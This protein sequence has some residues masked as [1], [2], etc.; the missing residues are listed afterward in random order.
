MAVATAQRYA[1]TGA[2]TAPP[3]RAP[4]GRMESPHRLWIMLLAAV[5]AVLL[6]GCVA[7][8]GLSGRQSTAEHT[9]QAT[10]ALYS[11]VQ[12][13]SYNLADANA[14]AA[15]AL[16]IGPVTPKPFTDRFGSDITQVEDLLSAASQ[17]VTGDATASHELRL[18][19]EQVPEYSQW[20]GEALANNRFGYP[21]AGAYLRQAS[22][23]LTGSMVPEVDTVITEEQN[24]TEN[25]ISSA[26][27]TDW[28]TVGVCVLAL[29]VLVL[30]GSVLARSTKRR[31]NLGVVAAKLAVLVLLGWTFTAAVGSSGAASTARGDFDLIV[32]TQV[33]ASQ[34]AT[35]E[36]YIALQQ[37]DRGENGTGDQQQATAALTALGPLTYPEFQAATGASK[38]SKATATAIKA[39]VTCG[40]GAINQAA[41]GNYAQAIITTVGTGSDVGQGGCEPA[42]QQVRDDLSALTKQSQGHY[43]TDMASVSSAYAGGGALVLPLA[44]GLLGAVAAAWGINR[45]L[46]EY[47]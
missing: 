38:T 8:T 15:T 21:V 25:G 26:S 32:Q 13:L 1:G 16:L 46:A 39:M 5:I 24:A 30:V 20:V 31:M 4:G 18:L 12:D 35:S 6:A 28:L 19:A 33:G 7:A 43:D 14:T 27:G 10:E 22:A 9:A 11:E 44:L 41:A 17:R 36:A 42:A 37:I 23:M 34:L 47:R 3:E 29:V 40:E 2:G 45:R